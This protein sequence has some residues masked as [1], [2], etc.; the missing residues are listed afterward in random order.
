MIDQADDVFFLDLGDA[1]RGL[2]GEDLRALVVERREAYE[3]E[4][5]RRHSPPAPLRRDRARG[6]GRTGRSAGRRACRQSSLDWHGDGPGASRA[7]TRWGASRAR[8]ILVAP[9]TDPGWT[10][11]FLQQAAW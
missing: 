9:S 5:K 3:Q 10:P 6:R 11:L 1:R 7:R 8:E 4:L 2:A